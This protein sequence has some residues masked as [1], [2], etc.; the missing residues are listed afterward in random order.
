VL[1]YEKDE[2]TG[3]VRHLDDQCIGCQ[4]CILKC[5]YDVP[6]FNSR[7]GIVR[8]CDMCHQR[9]CAGEAPACVQACPT[10]AIRIVNVSVASSS[11]HLS[12]TANLQTPN[13]ELRSP[14]SGLKFPISDLR[15]SNSAFLAAAPDSALTLPTTRYVSSRPVPHGAAAADAGVARVQ[16]AH[17]PLAILLTL[18]Q[19]ALGLQAA[20]MFV[21]YY[22]TN[23]LEPFA[24]RTALHGVAALGLL[25]VALV[26]SVAHLGQPMRAWRVFLG[27]R[28]S[29]LSR[30]AVVFGAWFGALAA[31]ILT[32][33]RALELAA[34]AIGV[35]GVFSSAMIY[36]DT[37]RRG[38][39]APTVAAKFAGTVALAAGIAI[40]PIAG[41]AA[42]ALKLA[43]ERL[44]LTRG[45]RETRALASGAL[46]F[47]FRWRTLFGATGAVLLAFAAAG[48]TGAWPVGAVFLICGEIAE[49]VLFFR[50][51]DGSKMPGTGAS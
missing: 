48:E 30:E 15:S 40:S 18:S 46:R 43:C 6:K 37:G 50:A 20:G 39:R 35:T 32:G 10:H 38:W 23:R 34:L 24:E 17:T 51:V 16:P 49:R 21:T 27:L 41:A 7:L 42:V 4:Y 8:K 29:W 5:P 13:S 19:L 33:S 44:A 1:A 9:L 22:V 2:V 11:D 45:P 31:A 28:R 47:E 26:A 14:N 3:I 36:I 25:A 12:P